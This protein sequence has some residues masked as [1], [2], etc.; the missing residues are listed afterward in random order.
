M[1]IHKSEFILYSYTF[2][3]PIFVKICIDN[4]DKY[5]VAVSL[6]NNVGSEVN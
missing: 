4:F 5:R 6:P 2:K 1:D 3:R